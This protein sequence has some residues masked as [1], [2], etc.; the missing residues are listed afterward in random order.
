MDAA[1]EGMLVAGS[2]QCCADGPAGGDRVGADVLAD[3]DSRDDEIRKLALHDGEDADNDGIDGC[4]SDC[5]GAEYRSDLPLRSA[6]AQ[7]RTR[8]YS[9]ICPEA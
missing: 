4:S 8:T 5:I 6:A 1:M 9:L 2:L 7:R 3:I